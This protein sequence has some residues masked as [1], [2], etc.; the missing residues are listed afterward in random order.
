[1]L[2]KKF[3]LSKKNK[4]IT[5]ILVVAL[6]LT[7]A[8]Y[9]FFNSDYFKYGS[10]ENF[11]IYVI[12]GKVPDSYIQKYVKKN[13]AAVISKDIVGYNKELGLIYLSD[14]FLANSGG[15]RRKMSQ[16]STVLRAYDNLYKF[17]ITLNGKVLLDGIVQPSVLLNFKN[18][19]KPYL[20][21]DPSGLRIKH[22]YDTDSFDE[23]KLEN[24]AQKFK[25]AGLLVE[26]VPEIGVG[27]ADRSINI[28]KL[29]QYRTDSLADKDKV[30][31]ICAELPMTEGFEFKGFKV[32]EGSGVE[33]K[34]KS[35]KST[36]SE[37]DY[38]DSDIYY[39]NVVILSSL[40]KDL[41]FVMFEYETKSGEFSKFYDVKKVNSMY[42]SKL[43]YQTETLSGL[44]EV[45]TRK[46]TGLRN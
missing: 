42:G 46:K 19:N 41:E 26:G 18:N 16:G 9:M 27:G 45:I 20:L 37:F 28:E 7:V 33:I 31:A 23:K 40:V 29:L 14:K 10:G 12:D 35:E 24:L 34:L 39:L 22:P 11:A 43:F 8:C 5:I 30:E 3:N 21:D 1:M 4:I 15:I 6:V 32:I 17:A 36:A 25:K 2:T 38:I 13:G 44:Y